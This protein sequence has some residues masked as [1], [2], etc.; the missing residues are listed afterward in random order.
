M[1]TYLTRTGLNCPYVR[2]T[3]GTTHPKPSPHQLR[4]GPTTPLSQVNLLAH[5]HLHAMDPGLA[6]YQAMTQLMAA[7]T[8]ARSLGIDPNVV[9]RDGL[10][11]MKASAPLERYVSEYDDRAAARAGLGKKSHNPGHEPK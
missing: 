11:S 4:Q 1:L 10:G 5:D 2:H 8:A 9:I 6:R 3:F 7:A